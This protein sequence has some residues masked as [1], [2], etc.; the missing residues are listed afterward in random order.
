MAAIAAINIATLE[1]SRVQATPHRRSRTALHNLA[2]CPGIIDLINIVTAV[3]IRRVF[4]L[5]LVVEVRRVAVALLMLFGSGKFGT[6]VG[7]SANHG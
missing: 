7:E 4:G 1:S 6:K 3:R 2:A 5:L